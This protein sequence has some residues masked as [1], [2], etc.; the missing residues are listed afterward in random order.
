MLAGAAI[1]KRLNGH[2]HAVLSALRKRPLL[3]G[4]E[5]HSWRKGRLV[6][7]HGPPASDAVPYEKVNG[8]PFTGLS[9]DELK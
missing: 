6:L 4:P 5:P 9:I 1:Q 2:F 8:S 7:R 3:I